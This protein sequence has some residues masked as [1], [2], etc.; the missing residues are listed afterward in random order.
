MTENYTDKSKTVS[1]IKRYANVTTAVSGFA[2]RL[3]GEKYLGLKI[4]RKN[5]A[6]V[7]KDALGGLKGPLMKVAQ[8]L[9][10]IPD[11]IPAEYREELSEL[12]TDAPSMGWLFVKRRMSSELG[13]DWMEKF[14]EFRKVSSFAASLGQVHKALTFKDEY[15]ACK[16]QYPDMQSVIEADLSQLKLA[17]SVYQSYDSAISTKSIHT[18]LQERLYEE[19]DYKRELA[20]LKIYQII[21]KDQK[22]VNVPKVY[23]NLSSKQ[24]LTMSWLEGEK[25]TE[26]LKKEPSLKERNKIALNMFRAWYLPFYYFGIIHGDP[27]LGNYS[28]NIKN[29]INLLDFGSIRFFPPTFVEGVIQLYQS[30]KNNNKDLAVEAYKK[31]G[32]ENLNNEIIEILNLWA[33]FIYA[34]LLS[35]SS[36][37]IS[38]LRDS[39]EGRIVASKVHE[40]LKKIGGVEPPREFVLMDR[41][42]VGL[43]SV[44]MRL[45]SE[46]NWHR[47]FENIIEEFDVKK[48]E[49]NQKSVAKKV[50]IDINNIK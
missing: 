17:F 2:A 29:E 27:H 12:Q 3:A 9:S 6:K 39:S 44:F 42:A 36:K 16:L 5:H 45:N 34:P 18:E 24:L 48:L 47:T 10:T 28:I 26:W 46:I 25:L 40:E 23:E 33:R 13:S 8:I 37:P 31:W 49:I 15:L 19:L 41:A 14:K 11:A 35:D 7:L 22:F 20:N 38:Q 4:D 32:F 50:G 30:L 21:L 1:K 43:G